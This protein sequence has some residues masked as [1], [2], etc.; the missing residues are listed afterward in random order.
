VAQNSKIQSANGKQ[1]ASSL[2][3]G[4]MA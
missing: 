3:Q 1:P 2:Q 4:Q